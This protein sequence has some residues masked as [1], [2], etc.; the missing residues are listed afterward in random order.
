M[1][2]DFN[3]RMIDVILNLEKAFPENGINDR[4]D[5]FNQAIGILQ[6]HINRLEKQRL[7]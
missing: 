7:T 6:H 2:E 5:A 1:L 4:R 3:N